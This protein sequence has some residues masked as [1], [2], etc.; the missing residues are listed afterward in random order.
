MA[1]VGRGLHERWANGTRERNRIRYKENL[2]REKKRSV[3]IYTG[4]ISRTLHP[5]AHYP[6]SEFIYHHQHLTTGD[7]SCSALVPTT[8]H[9][10]HHRFHR[11]IDA[12]PTRRRLCAAAATSFLFRDVRP[13]NP[14][15]S[16]CF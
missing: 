1:R 14:L 4:R 3:E 13:S 6:R 8:Y 5:A 7:I 15:E 11:P 2:K 16:C 9:S 12:A 10:L